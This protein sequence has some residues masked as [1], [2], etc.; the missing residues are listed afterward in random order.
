MIIGSGMDKMK[1][2]RQFVAEAAFSQLKK[3]SR[4]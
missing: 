1:K 2:P 4:Q 3:S